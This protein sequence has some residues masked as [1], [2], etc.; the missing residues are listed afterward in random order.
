MPTILLETTIH[1]P[2]TICFDLSRSLD[3]HMLS[4]SKTHEKAVDGRLSGLISLNETVTWRAKH[5]GIYQHLSVRITQMDKPFSFTDEMIKGAFKK[6]KHQHT[7]ETFQN[8]TIM[9][10]QF[11]FESPLGILGHL[12][13]YLILTNYMRNFLIER[14]RIIKLVAE[15]GDY[16]KYI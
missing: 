5:F 11:Y 1:A 10:D 8:D 16:K 13:N 4:T 14:N 3:L 7:F 2:I 6:M 15:N 12:F 9:R